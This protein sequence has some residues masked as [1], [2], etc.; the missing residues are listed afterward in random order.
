[1]P[2]QP[3]QT[4]PN[5]HREA[6]FL[7]TFFNDLCVPVYSKASPEPQRTDYQNNKA[8]LLPYIGDNK[9]GLQDDSI[10]QQKQ[11]NLLDVSFRADDSSIR[12]SIFNPQRPT[13]IRKERLNMSSDFVTANKDHQNYENQEK[14]LI[15]LDR[16]FEFNG[17]SNVNSKVQKL[18]QKN[19]FQKTKVRPHTTNAKA[20]KVVPNSEPK[21]PLQL[22]NRQERNYI[23]FK[24]PFENEAL[25]I[26][27]QEHDLMLDSK[28]YLANHIRS[29]S[30]PEK[31][32]DIVAHFVNLEKDSRTLRRNLDNVNIDP[33]FKARQ[34]MRKRR[35]AS[36]KIKQ[37]EQVEFSFLDN[38]SGIQ[39]L[40]E[41]Y[42]KPYIKAAKN[43]YMMN[44]MNLSTIHRYRHIGNR[45]PTEVNEKM[46]YPVGGVKVTKPPSATTSL[47]RVVRNHRR[48]GKLVDQE[49]E[50]PRI[51]SFK[52]T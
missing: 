33:Q 28:T 7:G 19:D 50:P 36:V 51:H 47:R 32:I 20:D 11:Q 40:D 12:K 35:S 27:S 4:T 16:L 3:R 8:S 21:M 15:N 5:T 13:S 31:P 52:I 23:S 46:V 37:Q 17:E 42:H 49:E 10:E 14:F 39:I 9:K 6:Q 30:K 1:M 24:K 25:P 29:N 22:H 43:Q 18:E 34:E 38:T 45:K 41:T 48:V 2:A 44:V 26:G